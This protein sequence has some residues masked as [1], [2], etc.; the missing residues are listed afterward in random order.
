M[1]YLSVFIAAMFFSA[2]CFKVEKNVSQQ[3]A[4]QPE[5]SQAVAVVH[6]LGN[7]GV[8]G[9]VTFIREENGVRVDATVRGLNAGEH[10]F[11]IHQYGDCTAPDGTSAGG[12]FNPFGHEHDGPEANSRHMGDMGNLIS[13]GPEE[14]TT[15]SYLDEVISLPMIVGRG[16]IIHAGEDDLSSQPSGEAGERIA[17]G[18]I[19]ITE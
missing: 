7:S 2:A 4:D 12:H 18:V 16:I 6:P 5:I 13:R 1:K 15:Y 19:G 10:G 11:H 8:S 17:C 9:T 3:S 14:T